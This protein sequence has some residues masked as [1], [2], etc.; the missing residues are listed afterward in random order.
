[1]LRKSDLLWLSVA[2]F[3][4]VALFHTS[5]RVQN[6]REEISTL[7]RQIISEQDGIRVA[8]AEWGILNDPVRLEQL[9][10][11][12]LTLTPITASQVSGFNA[13]PTRPA[14]QPGLPGGP[15]LVASAQ[16][17]PTAAPGVTRSGATLTAAPVVAR[18]LASGTP[19][20]VVARGLASGTSAPV[21]ARGAA[22]VTPAP[23]VGHAAAT[24]SPTLASATVAGPPQHHRVIRPSQPMSGQGLALTR[25]SADGALAHAPANDEIGKLLTRLGRIQ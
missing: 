15:A 11:T 14:V 8:K 1:M 19:A 18:G 10:G 16:D 7:D 2:A 20:P 4:G 17:K 24:L 5:Y 12:Y 9:A 25:V 13:L 23:V 21:V 6:L 3:A 22:P